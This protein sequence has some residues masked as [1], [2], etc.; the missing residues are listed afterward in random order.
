MAK[1]PQLT[2]AEVVRR[3]KRLGFEEDHTKGSHVVL[4]HPVTANI[5]V[6][7]CWQDCKEGNPSRNLKRA[8]VTLEQF[9]DA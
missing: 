4:K 7:S 1:V 5:T 3:L 2:G 9:L 8:G 6:V